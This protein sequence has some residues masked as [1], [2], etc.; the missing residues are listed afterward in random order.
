MIHPLFS[1]LIIIIIEKR[2]NT[3][4]ILNFK[5]RYL[6]TKLFVK[7]SVYFFIPLNN[8]TVNKNTKIVL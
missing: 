4:Q 7:N 3:P 5:T 6:S 1:M 2:K 8:N